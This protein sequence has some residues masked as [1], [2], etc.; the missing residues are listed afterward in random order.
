MTQDDRD[1]KPTPAE[2]VAL[3][4]EADTSRRAFLGGAVA[5]VVAGS[6]LKSGQ[7]FA[8]EA[9]PATNLAASPPAGFVP[10]AAPGRIVKVGKTDS[11]MPNKIFPKEDDAKAMLTCALMEL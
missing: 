6:V 7:A 11:L 4:I 3:H 9:P 10:F 1:D 5:A 8:G 2:Q